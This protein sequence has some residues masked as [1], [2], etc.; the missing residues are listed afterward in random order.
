MSWQQFARSLLSSMPAATREHY[1]CKLAVYLRWY[2]QRDF[3]D[4]IPDWQ[5]KDCGS[6]DIPS[7]RRICKVLLGN[8]FWCRALSFSPAEP[9][10]QERYLS[11]IKRKQQEWSGI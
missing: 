2:Q 9:A 1:T 8:D 10:C 11:R 4:G 7:W 6:A 5:E 3:P